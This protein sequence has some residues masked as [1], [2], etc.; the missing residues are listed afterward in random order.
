MKQVWRQSAAVL[1]RGLVS[2]IGTVKFDHLALE[3]GVYETKLTAKYATRKPYEKKDPR[4]IKAT[5]PGVMADICVKIGQPVKQGDTLLILEA[6]KMLNHVQSQMDGSIKTI[7]V[8]AGEK[9]VKGQA[10][11]ELE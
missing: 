1:H 8:A 3:N 2:K 4:V 5:I 11:I 6:M 10:L 9:V 7:H